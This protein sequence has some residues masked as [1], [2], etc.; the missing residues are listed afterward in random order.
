MKN[1]K[2]KLTKI[3]LTTWVS[4][5]PALA[6]A[7]LTPPS[8]GTT[9]LPDYGSGGLKGF[10]LFITQDI[11]VFAGFIAVLFIIIGGYQYMFSGAN[12]ELAKKGKTTLTNAVIG[13]VIII[14]SYTIVSIVYNTLTKNP[15][16]PLGVG[17]CYTP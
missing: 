5:A 14:L 6:Q 11:L 4:L 16:C 9:G 3:I 7:Q 8:R 17:T 13:L 15:T 10:I 12:E 2:H 1:L